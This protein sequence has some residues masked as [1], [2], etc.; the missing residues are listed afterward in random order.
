MFIVHR[1]M[2]ACCDVTFK[3]VHERQQF[4][5]RIGE[6]QLIQ[7][8]FNWCDVYG[9]CVDIVKKKYIVCERVTR[10]TLFIDNKC[11]CSCAVCYDVMVFNKRFVMN[12]K[13]S[14]LN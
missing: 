13:H 14:E 1:I 4:K 8:S 11:C 10:K 7:V 5:S 12:G 3:Y 6:F 9:N 2:Q